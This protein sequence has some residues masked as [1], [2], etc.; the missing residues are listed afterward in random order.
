MRL[1][2]LCD[3]LEEGW[4]SMDLIGEKLVEHAA[5]LADVTMIRYPMPRLG[6]LG[7]R[8]LARG[9]R[10]LERGLGRYVAYPAR[11]VGELGRFDA[12]HVADHSYSHLLLGL[13]RAKSGVYCHDIDAFRAAL[14]GAGAEPW[15]RALSRVLLTGLRRASVV[16]YST[17]AVCDEIVAEHLVPSERL[18]HAPYG[19]SPEFSPQPDEHDEAW[20]RHGDYVLHVGSLIPRKNPALL[21]GVYSEL[22]RQYPALKL[23]QIGGEWPA[24]ERARLA[25]TGLAARVVQ[26][27]GISRRELAAAYRQARVVLLPS[28]AE[29]FGLPIIE[30][31]ACGSAVIC[32][33][34]AVLRESGAEVADYCPPRDQK[35]WVRAV[36]ERLLAERGAGRETR[37]ERAAHFS[38]QRHARIIVDAYRALS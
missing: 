20:R 9:A 7:V 5:P 19:V 11:L 38:W 16:F 13:P 10:V 2:V 35:A 17:K 25:D 21:L 27:R 29:G 18:V 1:A 8:A 33:D 34:L 31:F 32:S 22:A 6:S 4:P 28:L 3:Y 36:G 24:E 15:R 23:V 14:P 26:Q 12:F 30:A 37:L